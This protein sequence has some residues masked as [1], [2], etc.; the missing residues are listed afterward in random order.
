VHAELRRSTGFTG[1]ADYVSA[2]VTIDLPAVT[3]GTPYKV[4]RFTFD[5]VPVSGSE[6]F[7]YKIL[8]DSAPSNLYLETYGIGHYPCSGVEETNENNVANPTVRG[9]PAGF[10]VFGWR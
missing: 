5:T 9:D 2:V 3:A 7:T 1:N 8:I 4:V 10:Q 6:T